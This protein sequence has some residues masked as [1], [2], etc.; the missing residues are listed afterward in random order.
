MRGVKSTAVSF[1]EDLGSINLS[2]DT[3]AGVRSR[4]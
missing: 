4:L 3:L 2:H 1:A